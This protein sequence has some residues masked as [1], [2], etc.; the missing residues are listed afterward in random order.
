MKLFQ[1][2]R[3]WAASALLRAPLTTKGNSSYERAHRFVFGE[4]NGERTERMN[5]LENAFAG[6]KADVIISRDIE[7]DIWKKYMFIAAQ[8]E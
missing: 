7:K 2:G 1:N 8:A 5:E 6:V 4:W 3:C